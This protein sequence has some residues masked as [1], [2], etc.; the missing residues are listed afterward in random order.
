MTYEEA[1][2]YLFEQT[3]N[4]EQQGQSGYK[5]GLQ[6]SEQLD[7]HYGHP[8]LAFKSIHIAGTNGKGSCSHSIAAILQLCGYRVGL[9][10]SPHLLDF[11]ER[12]RVDGQPIP[13]KYVIDFVEEGQS[14]FESIGASFFEITTAM[15]FKYFKDKD[16]D[17]AVIEVGL[18]GRLD[19]TN[20][21]TPIVSLITN[22]SMD[23]TQMLG[24][25]LEQIAMEKAGIIKKGV[26]AVI[27]ESLP[28]TRPVFEAQAKAMEAPIIFAEDYQEIISYEPRPEGGFIYQ[29]EHMGQIACELSG[30][31]Q[32]KNMSSVLPVL[33]EL[34]KAGYLCNCKTEEN[35]KKVNWE[36]NEALTNIN[37]LT[38][39]MGRWQTVRTH[40]TVICD[41]GHNVGG[42][43]FL[44]K[45]LS[46]IN[47]PLH[48]IFGM[49]ED[50]DVYGVMSLLPKNATYYYCKPQSKR[51]LSEQSVM[52]FGQQLGLTG[53]AYPSVKEAYS[54]ALNAASS[55]DFIFVGGS[56]YVV[57]EFLKTCF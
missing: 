1:T 31:Y 3:A 7:E 41:T 37:R 29:T 19:S 39:L 36:L 32:P 17:I 56:G 16:I 15:A 55:D 27:G 6:N 44:S 18:G 22:I 2:Q 34:V 54:T 28:E 33:N 21:I 8:H 20:I 53:Q 38:G 30:L 11:S 57:A 40:P 24:T 5:E 10:T 23:H 35:R 42:W 13:Q 43:E 12:I 51:A 45:Q 4:Y 47:S 26:P 46:A 49:L 9:Y 50:K 25:S 52:V 48:I 14:L